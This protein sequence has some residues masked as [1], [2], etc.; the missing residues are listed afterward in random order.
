M[1]WQFAAAAV[2]AVACSN[3]PEPSATASVSPTPSE[4]TPSVPAGSIV[5]VITHTTGFRH[6]SIP[7]AEA[8]ITALGTRGGFTVRYC[9]DAADVA[10]LLTADALK[11]VNAVFFANTTGNL[12]LPDLDGFFAWVRAG[13]GVLGAHSASDTYHDEPRYIDML[14]AEFRTHGNQANVDI[15]VEKQNHPAT[16]GLGAFDFA[17][18]KARVQ[19]FDEIYHFTANN[20]GRVDTLLSLDR[21]PAD[22]LPG[23]NQPADMPI[24]WA[25]TY[26]TGRVF[27]TAL[28]HRN[29]VWQDAR[30]QSHVLG[31]IRWVLGAN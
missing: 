25:K 30:F 27:Y 7:V 1:K 24:S 5:L 10:R 26:G 6:D 29:E 15:V 8:T 23:E 18:G 3:A 12:G 22:G 17:Q 11:Q 16:T 20:R 21:A 31:A 2:L 4:Q 9:R 14:G 28:G 19:F 13:G